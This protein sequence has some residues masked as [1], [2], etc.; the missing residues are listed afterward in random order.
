MSEISREELIAFTE[1]SNK[2]AIALEAITNRLT[3]IIAK[4]DKLIEKISNG[5]MDDIKECKTNLLEIKE[6]VGEIGKG[7]NDIADIKIVS[8]KIREDTGV[9][10]WALGI[11]VGIAVILETFLHLIKK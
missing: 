6:V 7:V 5:I 10:K 9:M 11:L 1:A 3:D 2:T 8:N 4:Q